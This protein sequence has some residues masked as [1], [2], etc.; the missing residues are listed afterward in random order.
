MAAFLVDAGWSVSFGTVSLTTPRG[1]RFFR[2]AP[3]AC[4]TN[5]F[6]TSA[7]TDPSASKDDAGDEEARLDAFGDWLEG[8]SDSDDDDLAV[9]TE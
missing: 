9:A 3:L 6:V 8:G 2:C 5:P 7:V 1:T 4:R